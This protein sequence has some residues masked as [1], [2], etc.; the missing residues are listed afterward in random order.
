MSKKAL[1]IKEFKKDL[2]SKETCST[3]A[4]HIGLA[5][6]VTVISSALMALAVV[7]TE[8]KETE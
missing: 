4:R 8:T 7:L 2:L 5:M 1:F 3:F 6:I